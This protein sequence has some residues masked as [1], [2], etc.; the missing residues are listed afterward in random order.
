M[1]GKSE[2]WFW[3]SEPRIVINLI[4]EK[5]KIERINQKN[6]ACYIACCVWGKDPNEID[7]KDKIVETKV[8][9]R[10][11]PIDPSLLRGL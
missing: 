2:E 8:A 5:K 9:G 1:L 7:G 4:S 10:D 3:S 11:K 6:L